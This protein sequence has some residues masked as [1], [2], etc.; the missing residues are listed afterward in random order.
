[1]NVYMHGGPLCGQWLCVESPLEVLQ[2]SGGYYHRHY[3]GGGTPYYIWSE[4]V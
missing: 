1:M 4:Y 2:L 3:A